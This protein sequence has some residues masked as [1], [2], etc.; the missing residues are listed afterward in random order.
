MDPP[1]SQA[2]IEY[3]GSLR[4]EESEHE[5]AKTADIPPATRAKF[6][7]LR[8]LSRDGQV[9]VREA[10]RLQELEAGKAWPHAGMR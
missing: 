9:V 3:L 2:E 7:H 6:H 10:E 1:R 8:H 4:S 5:A